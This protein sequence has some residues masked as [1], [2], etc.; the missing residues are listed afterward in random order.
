MS[1]PIPAAVQRRIDAILRRSRTQAR[2]MRNVLVD[3][4]SGCWVWQGKCS[5]VGY[6][7]MNMR[8]GDKVTPRQA[9]RV[10]WEAFH[11]RRIP[12]G[13][14]VAHHH[15]CISCTCCNPDHLRATTQ[16]ANLRDKKRAARWRLRNLTFW[17]Q[18]LSSF[19]RRRKT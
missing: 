14:V 10:S 8:E 6:A 2:I 18:P 5:N 11:E 1:G 9:H 12:A 16:S 4:A 7:V 3:A 15:K 13:R 17:Q 19:N